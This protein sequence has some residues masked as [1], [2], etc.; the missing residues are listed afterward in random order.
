M[1][2]AVGIDGGVVVETRKAQST[3]LCG[4]ATDA[5][6]QLDG[7]SAGRSGETLKDHEAL[8]GE[9]LGHDRIGERST[10]RLTVGSQGRRMVTSTHGDLIGQA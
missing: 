9:Q 8:F 6:Q 3:Q 1:H 7:S 10:D 2:L 4:P 5:G